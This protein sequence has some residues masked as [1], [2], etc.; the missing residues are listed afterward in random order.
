MFEVFFCHWTV[1]IAP[2]MFDV[3]NR[4]VQIVLVHFR[5]RMTVWSIACSKKSFLNQMFGNCEWNQF[6]SFSKYN[7]IIQNLSSSRSPSQLQQKH[8]L[9]PSTHWNQAA[10]W[11]CSPKEKYAE[12]R[13]AIEMPSVIFFN[14]RD[15]CA[16]RRQEPWTQWCR[17]QLTRC[18]C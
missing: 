8:L 2:K 7:S 15:S 5:I 18:F 12:N 6:D 4:I 3:V 16:S 17:F 10:Q 1:T 9:T 13:K 11:I 14:L